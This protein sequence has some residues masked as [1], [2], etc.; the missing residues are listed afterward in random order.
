[1]DYGKVLTIKNNGTIGWEENSG[2][3]GGGGGIPLPAT[4]S[5]YYIL[6]SND[7][8]DLVW[9]TPSFVVDM[10]LPEYDSDADNGKVLAIS[11]CA[12]ITWEYI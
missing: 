3:S 11:G 7:V 12:G 1:L 5:G 6:C 8:G 4:S 2:S 9:K 10:G